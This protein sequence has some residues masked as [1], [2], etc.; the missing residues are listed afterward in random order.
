MEEINGA[1]P[2][3]A[4]LSH[5]TPPN[6]WAASGAETGLS[7]PNV[8]VGEGG[9]EVLSPHWQPEQPLQPE[10]P[11]LLWPVLPLPLAAT[12][13]PRGFPVPTG[14]GNPGL[15]RWVKERR[16]SVAPLPPPLLGA[17]PVS[18]SLSLSQRRALLPASVGAKSLS[19]Q[20]SWAGLRVQ[21]R[22]LRGEVDEVVQGPKVVGIGHGWTV[23]SPSLFLPQ[24][25]KER[26]EE[27][28]QGPE[29]RCLPLAFHSLPTSLVGSLKDGGVLAGYRMPHKIKISNN[30]VE[31]AKVTF[32][33]ATGVIKRQNAYGVSNSTQKALIIHNAHLRRS[34]RVTESRVLY[35]PTEGDPHTHLKPE[36]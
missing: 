2:F 5:H 35:S 36:G 30:I 1:P 25:K 19:R 16:P 17:L 14:D 11:S 15:N 8:L 28:H 31:T 18:L 6:P 3:P 27:S 4:S 7:R 33:K 20:R 34:L 21:L 13:P 32:T 29:N 24:E 12:R 10:R 9:R 22:E 23:L 26:R